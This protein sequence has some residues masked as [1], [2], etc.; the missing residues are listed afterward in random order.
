MGN[1]SLKELAGMIGK[2]FQVRHDRLTFEVVIMDV[3]FRQGRPAFL[4]KP[5]AGSG[6]VWTNFVEA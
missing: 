2:T 6:E 5:V 3:E 1:K 4:V